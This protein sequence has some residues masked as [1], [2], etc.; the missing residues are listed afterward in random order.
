MHKFLEVIEKEMYESIWESLAA[1]SHYATY[2]HESECGV[3]E[4]YVNSKNDAEVIVTHYNDNE[5]EHTNI[6]QAVTDVIPDWDD[7]YDEFMSEAS[8]DPYWN[9]HGFGS[10]VDFETWKY[11]HGGLR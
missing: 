11:G 3:I 7:V 6:V 5:R 1:D 8:V 2:N 9:D 4:V 10:A